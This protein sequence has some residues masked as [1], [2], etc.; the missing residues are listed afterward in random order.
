M[1]DSIHLV[2]AHSPDPDDAFMWWPLV[3]LEGAGP[4]IDTGPFTFTLVTDDIESL[5]QAASKGMHDITAISMA[6][7]PAVSDTYVLTAC[8]A[9]VGDG[10]GPK[11]VAANAIDAPSLASQPRRIAVPGLHTTALATA[12]L[13]LGDKHAWPVLPFEMIPEAVAQ[14]QVDAGVVIH[15][16]QLTFE[17]MGLHLIEDL[18]AWWMRT[19]GLALPLGGNVV[20]RDIEQ[21]AGAG[22]LDRLASILRT[23]VEH[24]MAH[25]ETSLE[26]AMRFGRGID[27]KTTDTF[28]EMYV[29]RWTLDFGPT[30]HEALRR[31]LEAVHRSGGRDPGPIDIV[32]SVTCDAGDA[33]EPV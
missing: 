28:V 6:H 4:C 27:E 7:Y 21:R 33:K 32:G 14:G 22:S 29:N 23:S 1:S 24:A 11:L 13:L 10:Y 25:R 19:T 20:K 31:F 5:N 2:L 17:S 12:K 3:G 26:F 30:G 18:G 16:G 9:S 15:E 8:G